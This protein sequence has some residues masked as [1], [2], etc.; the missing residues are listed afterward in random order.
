MLK[1]I[2]SGDAALQASFLAGR[3]S[4]M[5]GVVALRGLPL[6]DVLDCGDNSGKAAKAKFDFVVCAHEGIP[7][8]AVDI[9]S[10]VKGS[11]AKDRARL[12][13][14]LCRKNSFPL[15]TV[16][17]EYLDSE[18]VKSVVLAWCIE[19]WFT[20]GRDIK[21]E[22]WP[23]DFFIGIDTELDK[24]KSLSGYRSFRVSVLLGEGGGELR[25]LASILINDSF[26]WCA[27]GTVSSTCPAGFEGDMLKVI[28]VKDVYGK[29]IDKMVDNKYKTK[30]RI[31]KKT[32]AF[33]KENN[34]RGCGSFGWGR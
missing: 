24:L 10:K 19:L 30:R 28:V 20:H 2:L 12:K 4:A 25:G 18:R 27:K 11:K 16:R 3:A 6:A 9:G 5:Y 7:L 17:S 14:R 26:G 33:R 13:H 15:F 31:K 22:I 8:F 21:Q 32:K 34:E 23:H 29:Y 1:N